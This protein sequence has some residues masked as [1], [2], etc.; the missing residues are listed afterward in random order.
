M[1]FYLSVFAAILCLAGPAVGQYFPP[2]PKDL[3]VVQSKHEGV[4][5]SYKQTSICET[6]PGV[7][8]YSGYV[9]LPPGN[10]DDVGIYQ[11]YSINTFFW[12]FEAR[13]DP[14]NAPLSIWMNGGPGSSSMIGMLMENGPCFVNPDSNSTTLNPWSWNRDVNML[15]LDQPVQTGFSYDTLVNVSVNALED[16]IVVEDFSKGVPAQSNT[17]LVGTLS[18]QSNSSTAN[19][20]ANAA[21]SL[22]H[23]SQVWFD[24]F[25]EYKPHNNKIS[26]WTESYGGKYGPAFMRFFHEQN[27]KIKD[28]T[29]SDKEY[30]YLLHLDTLG[31]ING[32]VDS[33]SQSL[34]YPEFARS[35]TYDIVTLNESTIQG[36]IEAYQKPGGCREMMENC[37]KLTREG[38]PNYYSN[39]STVNDVCGQALNFCMDEVEGPYYEFADRNPYDIAH[40]MNDPFPPRYM[41]GYL[42]RPHIQ[43]EL[44]VPLNFSVASLPVWYSFNANGDYT[45]SGAH[46]Y[47]NDI[48]YLLESGV[49]VALVYGDRD[50]SCNWIGGQ[51]VSLSVD[52]ADSSRFRNAGYADIQTNKSYVGGQVRQYGKFSFSRVYQ[53]GHMVPSYQPETAFE[54][55][56]RVM[57]DSDVATGEVD[58]TA[59]KDFST[60]GSLD[61]SWT[62]QKPP[63]M[64]KPTCYVLDSQTCTEDQAA[65]VKNGSALIRD[66]IVVDE[67]TKHLFPGIE[68][69]T[70]TSNGKPK[71]GAAPRVELTVGLLGMT[72]TVLGLLLL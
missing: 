44:G 3:K 21:R 57:F 26:M 58:I 53:A 67:N 29:I 19:N 62:K 68:W 47:L 70:P 14:A 6:T 46:G 42:N 50:F 4:T 38:D 40:P 65:S 71:K 28:G 34:S 33:F 23:F 63:P 25:P 7:K 24:E 15:Y 10:L 13:N 9:H 55:F 64:P 60:K 59:V 72:M 30:S 11:N 27:Q 45:S 17:H 2:T 69:P 32:C 39:N 22:W 52:Y 16:Q 31:I 5:I 18:S 36:M 66:Y 8:S 12:F 1:R 35:N 49:K 54:I 41:A 61:P 37:R 43:A 48:A 51:N 56:R 20:T